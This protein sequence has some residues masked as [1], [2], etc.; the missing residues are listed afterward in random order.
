MAIV[1]EEEKKSSPMFAVAGV[2]VFIVVIGAAAYYLFIAQPTPAIVPSSG[3]LSA[4][5]SL[6]TSPV[7][8]QDI[9]S[10]TVL[11]SFHT[12]VS[13]PTSTGPIG[14]G[15]LDPFVAP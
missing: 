9:E 5:A 10:S 12:S 15:R 1:V 11:A 2:L 14:V 13:A 6:T 3:G 4:I 8:P 7:Q